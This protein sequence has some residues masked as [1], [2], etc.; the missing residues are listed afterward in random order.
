MRLGILIRCRFSSL[1]RFGFIICIRRYKFLC[2]RKLAQPVNCATSHPHQNPGSHRT[3]RFIKIACFVPDFKKYIVNQVFGIFVGFQ[4]PDCN[5]QH[6]CY[7]ALVQLRQRIV[8]VFCDPPYQLR[9]NVHSAFDYNMSKVFSKN[10][11]TNI[12]SKACCCFITLLLRS[13]CVVQKPVDGA[14]DFGY[15]AGHI[16]HPGIDLRIGVA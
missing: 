3:A 16:F 9:I 14:V 5:G 15:I 6:L 1:N 4:N 12:V 8:I 7:M 11:I 2:T 10:R 13:R